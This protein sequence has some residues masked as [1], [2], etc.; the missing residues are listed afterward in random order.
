MIYIT[1]LIMLCLIIALFANTGRLIFKWISP[2]LRRLSS[3]VFGIIYAAVSVLIIGL[4]FLGMM[5][6]DFIPGIVF[7]I[8]NYALGFY[9]YIVLGVNITALILLIG[10]LMH[11][12]PK[13]LSDKTMCIIAAASLII[14]F[15]ASLYGSINASFIHTKNYSISLSADDERSENLRIVLLSDIHLGHNIT[16][17]HFEKIVNAVNKQNPDIVCIAGDIFDSNAKAVSNKSEVIAFFNSIESVYGTYACLGNH[18]AGDTYTLMREILDQTDITVLEDEYITIGNRFILGGR[19][20]SSPIGE[21][22]Q[23]QPLPELENPNELPVIVMDHQPGNINEYLSETDLILCGH[24]H[25]GQFFPVNLITNAIYDVDYGHY[26][27]S[28][29][30]P[31]VIVT[32][33]CGTWGPPQRIG[34]DNEIVCIDIRIPSGKDEI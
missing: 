27:A 24:T 33:G 21:Q 4:L 16:D 14:P 26:Q 13:K 2:V 25:K 19:L 34:S 1:L 10:K 18:D 30:A 23:R 31:Q 28:S 29:E 22:N 32:S 11:I 9:I 17:T 5:H 3:R 12:I 8:G 15:T 6:T 20:D 7:K